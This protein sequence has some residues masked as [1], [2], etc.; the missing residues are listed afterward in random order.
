MY[1][2]VFSVSFWVTLFFVCSLFASTTAVAQGCKVRYIYDNAGN[3]VLRTWYC[4]TGTTDP[5]E[6]GTT[7]GMVVQ[8]EPPEVEGVL[9]SNALSVHPNPTNATLNLRTEAP[10]ENALVDILD[11]HGQVLHTTNFTGLSKQFEVSQ[12]SAGSYFARLRL[13]DEM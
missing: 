7:E 13:N 11:A 8:D 12:Y 9:K 4:W 10:V 2:R 3:R 6:G 1:K 5:D